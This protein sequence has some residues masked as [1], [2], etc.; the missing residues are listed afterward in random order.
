VRASRD[1]ARADDA[2]RVG[3]V[4]RAVGR[5]PPPL[6]YN[7]RALIQRLLVLLLAAACSSGGSATADC[8]AMTAKACTESR[9]CILD[10]GPAAAPICRAATS[11]ERRLTALDVES[12]HLTGDALH[13]EIV[14]RC[15]ADAA[16]R[17][18]DRGCFCPCGLSGFPQCNCACGGGLPARCAE[19]H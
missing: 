12:L 13:R 5:V 10:K 3:R 14:S 18:E 9:E 15:E 19:R 16:C 4:H 1:G 2:G 6:R 17:Y 11:C 8:S 7:R